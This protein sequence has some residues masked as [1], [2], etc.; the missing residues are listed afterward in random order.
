VTVERIELREAI[1][2]NRRVSFIEAGQGFPVILLHGWPLSKESF[3]SVV[4]V[5]A[6]TRRA[7][8]LDLPGFGSSEPLSE[9]HS[10]P[11]LAGAVV[12]FLDSQK[13]DKADI[14]GVSFGGS[15]ALELAR[16]YPERVQRLVVNSPPL[17]FYDKLSPGQKLTLLL[18]DS[19]PIL[20]NILYRRYVAGSAVAFRL[21]FG[22]G[23]NISDERIRPLFEIARRVR[24]RIL[25]ETAHELVWTDLRPRVSLV[26]A[27]TLVLIGG[28]EGRF[29]R[30]Q[31]EYLVKNLPNARP[32]EVIPEAN[33]L[34]AVNRPQ[35]FALRVNRFLEE[36]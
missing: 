19:F 34:L 11:N 14:A 1:V 10:Y 23:A 28:R 5:L 3:A 17:F 2:R 13:I 25:D 27:P 12:H 26:R 20:K 7:L 22:R 33:H 21:I 35:E 30:K 9:R 36:D 16:I 24:L 8:A 6:E 29:F 32:L 15:L 4:T 18:V 31:S